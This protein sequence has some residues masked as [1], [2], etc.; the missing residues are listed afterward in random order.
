MSPLHPPVLSSFCLCSFAGGA[1]GRP[2]KWFARNR[3]AQ[4]TVVPP[5]TRHPRPTILVALGV[6]KQGMRGSKKPNQHLCFLPQ[7]DHPPSPVVHRSPF[8]DLETSLHFVAPRSVLPLSRMVFAHA[9]GGRETE[10]AAAKRIR[11]RSGDAVV[12]AGGRKDVGGTAPRRNANLLRRRRRRRSVGRRE[13]REVFEA[14]K[15]TR[16]VGPSTS[17]WGVSADPAQA[18]CLTSSQHSFN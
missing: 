14:S 1:V 4:R 12:R 11:K 5:C 16:I 9:G 10:A 18:P 7:S 6:K 15:R 2:C 8:C 3:H 17:Q 13:R